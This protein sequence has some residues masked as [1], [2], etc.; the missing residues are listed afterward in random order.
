MST[1]IKKIPC[2]KT[3]SW[4]TGI[5]LL[6]TVLGFWL[7]PT[8]LKDK[9]P[10]LIE[11]NLHRPATVEDIRFNPY[12]LELDVRRFELLDK[13]QKQFV[14]FDRFYVDIAF[15]RSVLNLNLSF[16]QILLN[17]PAGLIERYKN[18]SF[19]FS[20]LISNEPQ[21]KEEKS[22]DQA[23]P[24]SIKQL[25]I[26]DG[27]VLWKD[28]LYGELEQEKIQPL[29]LEIHNLVFSKEKNSMLDFTIK[30]A[31]GGSMAVQSDFAL[32]PLHADGKL[33][34]KGVNFRQVWELFL[35]HEVNFE[36]LKGS[37]LLEA[38]FH[39]FE[40]KQGIQLELADS[41]INIHNL[42]IAEMG[43]KTPVISLADFDVSGIKLDLQKQSVVI[44][45]ILSKD[46]RFI[47]WLSSEGINYQALFAPKNGGQPAAQSTNAPKD[48]RKEQSWQV[49]LNKFTLENYAVDFTDKTPA[50]PVALHLKG[51]NF[52]AGPLSTDLSASIP[53]QLAMQINQQGQL[54]IKGDA[55]AEPLKVNMQ[56]QTRKIGL[57]DFQPY[58]EPFVHLNFI[59]GDLNSDLTVAL[60]ANNDQPLAIKVK[61]NSYIDNLVTRDQKT[62]RDFL[63]WKRL[64]LNDIDL[65]LAANRYVINTVKL[66]RLYSRIE[67]RKDKSIN[68][69]DVI[70]T[71]SSD[72]KTKPKKTANTQQPETGKTEL[73]YQVGKI[74]IANGVSDFSDQSLLIPF[75]AHIKNLNGAITGVSS[76]P[77][78][79]IKLA[80]NGKVNGLAPVKIKG[81]IQPAREVTEFT[82]DF[83]NMSLPAVTPYMAEFAGRKIDKGKLSLKLDYKIHNKKLLASN[84][85]EINHLVLGEKIDNPHATSLPLDLAIALLEDSDGKIRL[86]LPIKGSLDDPEFSIWGVLGDVLVNVITKVVTSPFNAIA[87]LI[88][89]DEDISKIE[90]AAGTAELSEQQQEKLTALAEALLKRPNLSLEVTGMAYSVLDWPAMQKQALKEQ[91]MQKLSREKRAS[92]ED[93]KELLANEFIKTFP[94]LAE[95]SLFGT[96]RLKDPEAGD[97]YTIAEEKLAAQLPPDMKKLQ[98]LAEK[99]GQAIADFLLQ[100]QIKPERVFLLKAEVNSDPDAEEISVPLQL[101]VE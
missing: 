26:S 67:I 77:N 88:G 96:P 61:G 51:I 37:E 43:S 20:D 79:T 46:A 4:F 89:S 52:S 36:I 58:V 100:K 50:Q 3:L 55:I 6:Y 21:A 85:V 93:Y 87:S 29:N 14:G 56:L 38:G 24:L 12:T 97:F 69:N 65:D 47:S 34:L 60:A 71:A 9:L 83:R 86:D 10:E 15:W 92:E 18:G 101:T 62:N 57:K 31:S 17:K 1:W 59:S 81:R 94:Q 33:Q 82:L 75:Q 70:V 45:R 13:K 98:Q 76:K 32:T 54:S 90:F 80:L 23:I 74:I 27:S 91:L 28:Y 49:K 40:N 25:Q 78:A 2:K 42:Q 22:S 19:N 63:N 11:E 7:L 68:I 84:V 66:Q 8:L 16:E 72:S 64:S 35:K 44:D 30:L 48:Q 53:F 95:K 5:I 41:H 99:R 73:F 39:V